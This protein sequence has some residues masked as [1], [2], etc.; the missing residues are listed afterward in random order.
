MLDALPIPTGLHTRRL[1]CETYLPLIAH[2]M[3]GYAK[4]I[5]NPLRHSQCGRDELVGTI[6]A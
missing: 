5:P 3:H 4:K 1:A 6:M 2:R